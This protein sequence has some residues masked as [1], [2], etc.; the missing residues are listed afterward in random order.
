MEV[1][2]PKTEWSKRKKFSKPDECFTPEEAIY[3][4]IN[5]ESAKQGIL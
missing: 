4:L 3:P 2:N 1:V 5:L